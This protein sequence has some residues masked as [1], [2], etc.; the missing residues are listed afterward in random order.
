M[1]VLGA[2]S[3]LCDRC[4]VAVNRTENG[5]RSDFFDLKCEFCDDKSGLMKMLETE[6]RWVHY[7]CIMKKQ[8]P[9]SK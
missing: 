6:D 5:G 2:H 1:D 3:W 9:S 8:F 4:M 7:E